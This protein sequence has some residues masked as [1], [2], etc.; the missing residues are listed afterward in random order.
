MFHAMQTVSGMIT[1]NPIWTDGKRLLKGNKQ[2]V[3]TMMKRSTKATNMFEEI[4]FAAVDT[5]AKAMAKE[6]QVGED[7]EGN[8]IFEVQVQ[9]VD[10]LE[11]MGQWFSE[12]PDKLMVPYGKP[13]LNA[14][15]SQKYVNNQPKFEKKVLTPMG[16]IPEFHETWKVTVQAQA[17]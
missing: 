3:E 10:D 1:H 16:E 5:Y 8:P 9:P 7:D 13:V 17:N 6:V 2:G 4:A 11:A 15:G 14:D 12:N